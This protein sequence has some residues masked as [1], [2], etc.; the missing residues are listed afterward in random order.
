VRFTRVVVPAVALA[1]SAFSALA[2][3]QEDE[4]AGPAMPAAVE[5]ICGGPPPCVVVNTLADPA[6][7][8]EDGELVTFAAAVAAE[9]RP[10]ESCA[11]ADAAYEAEGVPVDAFLGRC[12][13]PASA[14]QVN[15]AGFAE[16]GPLSE[17]GE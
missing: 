11:K 13:G 16:G 3:A 6:N 8:G 10:D 14:E 15:E 7:T 12:P 4:P 1:M 2:L 9:G 5:E 17:G